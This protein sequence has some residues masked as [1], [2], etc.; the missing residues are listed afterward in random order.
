MVWRVFQ[1]Q[2]NKD[3]RGSEKGMNQPGNE[4]VN[5][6]LHRLHGLLESCMTES[7]IPAGAAEFRAKVFF[8]RVF[9]A[10]RGSNF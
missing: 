5:H 7:S 4:D 3:G 9:R 8:I 6:G 2:M 10:I 1:P